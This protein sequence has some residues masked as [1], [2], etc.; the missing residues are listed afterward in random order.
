MEALMERENFLALLDLMRVEQAYAP[1][2]IDQQ[3]LATAL[4]RVLSEAPDGE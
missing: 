1:P 4:V 3:K 2:P